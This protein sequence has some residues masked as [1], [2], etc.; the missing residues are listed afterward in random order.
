MSQFVL[1][2]LAAFLDYLALRVVR[3]KRRSLPLVVA[4][5]VF[6]LIFLGGSVATFVAAGHGAAQFGL[7]DD[8]PRLLIGVYGATALGAVVLWLIARRAIG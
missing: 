2:A 8:D 1:V 4:Y 3:M 5:P 7:Q 6:V